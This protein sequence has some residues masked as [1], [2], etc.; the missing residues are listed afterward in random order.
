MW[1]P[2]PAGR[3]VCRENAN[4]DI[5]PQRGGAAFH[6]RAR[7]TGPT[8]LVGFLLHRFLQTCRAYGAGK[9]G[10]S[11]LPAVVIGMVATTADNRWGSRIHTS[12]VKM[13]PFP[14]IV[15]GPPGP[16]GRNVCRENGRS[17][18]EPQRGGTDFMRR[19][20]VSARRALSI[21]LLRR[22]LQTCRAYGAG[23]VGLSTL[24][25]VVIGMVATTAG[26]RCGSRTHSSPVNMTLFPSMA[27]GPPDPAGRNV[28]I[29][30]GRSAIEP[31]RGGTDFHS[32]QDV[33]ARRASSIFFA[34]VSTNMPRL[35][36]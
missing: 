21:F 12:P 20:D 29:E 14:S 25:A 22:S 24:P 36:R 32:H 1:S 11:T 23:K 16:A 30:N 35:R 34:S 17:A 15:C 19:K 9:V 10:L 5:E 6:S 3:N 27:Y 33:P 13:T 28:S 7:R 8:G 18:I 2:G 4:G 31:Q 26:N